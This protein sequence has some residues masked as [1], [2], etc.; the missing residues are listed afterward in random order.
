MKIGTEVLDHVPEDAR[1]AVVETLAAKDATNLEK[2]LKERAS[3][4]RAQAAAH[5]VRPL[6]RPLRDRGRAPRRLRNAAAKRALDELER[7]V[8]RLEASGPGDRVAIDLSDLRRHSYYTG[9][10]MTLLAAGPGSRSDGWRY[11]DLLRRYDA[12]GAA[13]GF[14]FEV[15]NVL[16]ALS[17]AASRSRGE[18]PLRAVVAAATPGAARRRRLW[19]KRDGARIAVLAAKS[20]SEARQYAKAWD[21]DLSIWQQGARAAHAPAGRPRRATLRGEPSDALFEELSAWARLGTN[22]ER[23]GGGRAQWGDEGKARWSTCTR[24]YADLVVRYAGGQ[25][26]PHAGGRRREAD[27]SSDPVRNPSRA[28]E[29]VVG[30]G[31]VVD[32]AVFLKEVEA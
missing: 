22:H 20:D 28:D 15:D 21:Y 23:I 27:P 11:D 9:V 7:V 8:A 12:P 13:T 4:R 18:L 3:S 29:V 19:R 16:W 17:E 31:T 25:T 10:S 30:Q 26:R 2:L 32:P 24:P 5:A 14:A 6:R 1:L